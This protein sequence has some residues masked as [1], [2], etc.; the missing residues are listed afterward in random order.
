MS[1]LVVGLTERDLAQ[2]HKSRRDTDRLA[3]VTVAAEALACEWALPPRPR[4]EVA[5]AAWAV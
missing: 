2:A 5:Q 1:A 4:L 3:Q